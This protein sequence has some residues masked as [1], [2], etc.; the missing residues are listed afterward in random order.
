[1]QTQIAQCS[2]AL[3]S[4]VERTERK[5]ENTVLQINRS[6]AWFRLTI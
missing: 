3:R 5:Q 4:V 2:Y 6:M 1:M